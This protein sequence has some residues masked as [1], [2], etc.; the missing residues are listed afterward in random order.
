MAASFSYYKWV[1]I[2]TPRLLRVMWNIICIEWFILKGSGSNIPYII[3]CCHGPRTDAYC[4]FYCKDKLTLACDDS[5]PLLCFVK[6]MYC[7]VIM[8]LQIEWPSV[9]VCVV[10]LKSIERRCGNMCVIDLPQILKIIYCIYKT[11]FI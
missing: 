7:W 2:Q 3:V 4:K 5:T 8:K 9:C 11:D 10:L 6:R 1:F